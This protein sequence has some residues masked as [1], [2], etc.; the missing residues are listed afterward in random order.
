MKKK[1]YA[2]AFFICIFFAFNSITAQETGL[3]GNSVIVNTRSGKVKGIVQNQISVFR[4]IP[5]AA[6]P[7]GEHRFAAPVAHLRWD[8]IRDATNQRSYGAF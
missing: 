3:N 5:Y 2:A 6:P 7:I 1:L 4:G 8:G